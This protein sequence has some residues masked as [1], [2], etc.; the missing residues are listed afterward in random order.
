[1]NTYFYGGAF[2]P[3]TNSHMKIIIDILSEMQEDDLLVIGITDH[4]YKTF[5]YD[6]NLRNLILKKNC[7]EYCLY[8]NKK[9]KLIKQDKR[10]WKFLNELGYNNYILVIGEDEYQDLINNKWHFS[11]EILNNFKIKV[12]ERNDGVSST[13][14]R[15]LLNDN[16]FEEVKKYISDITLNIL[17]NEKSK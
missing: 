8:P 4:D 16:N 17:I 1:M 5:Q 12:I 14:V 7:L 2:N 6:Y 15:K 9:I 3:L 13:I 11:N 10:T